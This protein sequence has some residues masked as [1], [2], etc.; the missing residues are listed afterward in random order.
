MSDRGL[1]RALRRIPILAAAAE[2]GLAFTLNKSHQPVW[3]EGTCQYTVCARCKR[4]LY[5]KD[6]PV[7]PDCYAPKR[8]KRRA[9]R[10]ARKL[11]KK[12]GAA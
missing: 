10:K 2:A 4:L 8:Q 9:A 7:C 11:R 6:G 3:S 5:V 1:M 12:E